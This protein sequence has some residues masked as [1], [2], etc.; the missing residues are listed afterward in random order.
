MNEKPLNERPCGVLHGNIDEA[1]EHAYQ[2]L[3]SRNFLSQPFWGTRGG[4]IGNVGKVIG[5]TTHDGRRRWRLDY[6][7]ARGVHVNEEDFTVTPP[8]KVVHRTLSSFLLAD[9]YWRKWTSRYDK[10]PHVS[11]AEEEIDRQRRERFK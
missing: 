9:T 11:D 10:P 7:R 8:R 6:D 1:I 5:W 4:N 2:G 3:G